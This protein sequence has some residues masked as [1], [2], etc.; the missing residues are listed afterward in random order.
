MLQ[1]EPSL[2]LKFYNIC[3]GRHRQTIT[4]ELQASDFS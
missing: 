3:Y 2:I 1:T 4:T